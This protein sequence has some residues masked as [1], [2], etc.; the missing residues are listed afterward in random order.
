MLKVVEIIQYTSMIGMI[1]LSRGKRRGNITGETSLNSRQ[2]RAAKQL[3]M[4]ALEMV[5]NYIYTL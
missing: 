4:S 5:S 3:A 2:F 1:L